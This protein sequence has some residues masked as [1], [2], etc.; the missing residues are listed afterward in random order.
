MISCQKQPIYAI[1]TQNASITQKKNRKQ[2]N[3]Q[4]KGFIGIQLAVSTQ[5]EKT[6]EGHQFTPLQT[7]IRNRI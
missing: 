4:E 7:V 6:F 2:L 1:M 5:E 3:C